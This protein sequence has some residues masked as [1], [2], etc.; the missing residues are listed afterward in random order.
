M[1]RLGEFIRRL[2]GADT[3]MILAHDDDAWAERFAPHS[4]RRSWKGS[5]P[6]S[7]NLNTCSYCGSLHPREL[8]EAFRSGQVKSVAWADWKYGWP[9]KLYVRVPNEKAGQRVRV[10][11]TYEGK[12]RRALLGTGPA[13]CQQ[14]FYSIHLEDI[15]GTPEFDALAEEIR[16]RTGVTFTVEVQD[17]IDGYRLHWQRAA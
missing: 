4:W 13:T 10:G 9:H 8:L 12:S 7:H 14:K 11:M 15:A 1:G 3:L 6:C 2:L 5:E 16:A 17:S